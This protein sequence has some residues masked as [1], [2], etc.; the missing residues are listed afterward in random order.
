VRVDLPEGSATLFPG[1][2][3]KVGFV[4]GETRRLL[5][6]AEGIVRRSEL[7][8]VYVV[9]EERVELRQVRLGRRYDDDIEVLAGL[10][11]GE[12]VALDPVR[13]G[14]YVKEQQRAAARDER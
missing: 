2:F 13:A 12:Q 9:G 11:E 10:D 3:V 4:V 8:A 6:P 1:M 5:I 14:I 7:S